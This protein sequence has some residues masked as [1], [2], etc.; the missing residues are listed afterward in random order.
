MNEDEVRKSAFAGIVPEHFGALKRFALS[1][2]RNEED[3]NDLVAGTFLKAYEKFFTIK[4]ERKMRQWLFRIM[5]NH[6]VSNLRSRKNLVS[7]DA[8]ESGNGSSEADSFSLFEAIAKSNFVESGTPEKEFISKL[9][10][11]E[12]ETAIGELPVEFRQAF[13]LCDVDEFSY[14]EISAILNVPVGTVRS[15]ISRA[16]SALQQKLWLQAREMGIRKAEKILPKSEYTCNC[17]SEESI[18]KTAIS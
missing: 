15:R 13:V 4:D 8:V 11:I 16:R 14:S 3:A 18:E 5:N 10:M 2:C 9:T 1:L 12:I 7:L 17:G 6:F